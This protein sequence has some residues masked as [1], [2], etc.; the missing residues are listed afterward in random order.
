MDKQ[1]RTANIKEK[2]SLPVDFN[3][4][5]SILSQISLTGVACLVSA[6]L[7]F[8]L[9]LSIDLII[10]G[11][12]QLLAEGPPRF[13]ELYLIR[14]LLLAASGGLAVIGLSL[15]LKNSASTRSQTSEPQAG[16]T[17]PQVRRNKTT[18]WIY[19]VKAW[20]GQ[21]NWAPWLLLGLGLGFVGLFLYSP[22]EFTLQAR[23]DMPVEHLSAILAILAGLI[24]LG[25]T[26]NLLKNRQ[27]YSLLYPAGT[28]ALALILFLLALEEISWFQRILDIETL[29]IMEGS[30][31]DENN[32][33][34]FA[35]DLVENIYYSAAFILLILI[36]FIADRMA[37][38]PRWRIFHFFAPGKFILLVSVPLMA[39]TY[40][41]WN[42]I[43]VQWAFFVTAAILLLE[44]YRAIR[45][46]RPS[47]LYLAM[48]GF[49]LLAQGIFLLM[50][51]RFLRTWDVTE[52]KE[53]FIPIALLFYAWEVW[54]KTRRPLPVQ[55]KSQSKTRPLGAALAPDQISL[56]SKP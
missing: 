38:T 8:L 13:D 43:F 34:N 30:L 29:D 37:R 27:A 46:G 55:Q 22:R 2:I 42:V 4:Q 6:Y 12:T 10:L 36:P 11:D 47:R 51:D 21:K 33:H 52:Y 41:M 39:F 40:D 25:V 17:T 23:E 5:G 14:M 32:L 50:G 26:R 53:L 16:P 56:R 48:L 7:L 3:S 49:L 35:T 45:A 19:R 24:F 20:L 44:I 9:A 15:T 54:Q 1:A 18:A 31:R 28:L